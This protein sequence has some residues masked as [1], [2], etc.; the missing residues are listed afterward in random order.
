MHSTA[1]EVMEERRQDENDNPE[2]LKELLQ[3][4]I[5][6]IEIT[7]AKHDLKKIEETTAIDQERVREQHLDFDKNNTSEIEEKLK[8][9]K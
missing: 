3:A 6:E 5:V 4:K 9:L 7:L 8:R 2:K 1:L